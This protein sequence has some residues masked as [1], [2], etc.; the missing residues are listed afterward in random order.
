MKINR[1]LELTIILLNRK[2]ATA[3]DLAERFGVS[4]RTIYRDLDVLSSAGVPVYTNKGNKGGISLLEEY[5]LNKTLISHH[6][7]ESLI[8]ALKTLQAIKYPQIDLMLD[9]LGGIF[10]NAS[11]SDWVNIDFSPWGS[12]PDEYNKFNDIKKAIL[13]RYI[14]EFN[15]VNAEGGQTNRCLEPMKL[16]FKGQAWYL[17]GY[18]RMRDEFR[19]F[20]ISR[21][22]NLILKDETFI[23]RNDEDDS[24]DKEKKPDLKKI[25]T[26]KLRFE[27]EVLNRVYDDFDDHL[28]KR[29]QDGTCEIT[30]TFPLDEWVYGYIMSYGHFVTVL[31]PG[32][33]KEIICSRMK[34]TLEKYMD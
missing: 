10:K 15:Y 12:R 16:V 22:K 26:L 31:E 3:K 28:I 24:E 19:I 13:E 9:K 5:S 20:R 6:E 27:P 4:T 8:F 34:K 23:R 11:A 14:I 17:W 29:N 30:V 7:S 25:V 2:C 21:I 18:C 32:Y 1:L 33:F